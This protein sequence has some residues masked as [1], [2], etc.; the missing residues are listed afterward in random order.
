MRVAIVGFMAFLFM[1]FILW[2]CGA[3]ISGVWSPMMWVGPG[4]FLYVV[5]LFIVALPTG[6]GCGCWY[7]DE[8]NRARRRG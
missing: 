8:Q 3:F 7:H 2:L 4:R 6:I 1:G 5:M